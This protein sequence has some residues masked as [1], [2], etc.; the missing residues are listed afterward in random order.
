MVSGFEGTM[1]Q[2]A[3]IDTLTMFLPFII[4]L[5]VISGTS[6]L[7]LGRSEMIEQRENSKIVRIGISTALGLVLAFTATQILMT[8]LLL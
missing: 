6:Y 1:Q 7:L 2:M 5:G 3:L 4:S 8:S